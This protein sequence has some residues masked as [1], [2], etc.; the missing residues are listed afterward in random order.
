M[1]RSVSSRVLRPGRGWGI[2]S[3]MVRHMTWG[4]HRSTEPRLAGRWQVVACRSAAALYCLMAGGGRTGA[5]GGTHRGA[6]SAAEPRPSSP[7]GSTTSLGEV[8]SRL[9]MRIGVRQ[10]GPR[11]TRGGGETRCGGLS[12][13]GWAGTIIRRRV[14]GG[15]AQ[16]G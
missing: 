10:V 1:L 15:M 14:L 13:M 5:V 4:H 6:R 16:R 8:Q 7:L 2:A 12:G 11:A 3:T 9:T